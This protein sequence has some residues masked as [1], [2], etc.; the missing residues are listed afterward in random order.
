MYTIHHSPRPR[1]L[2]AALAVVVFA[3][4]CGD[5]APVAG[6]SHRE[7]ATRAAHAEQSVVPAVVAPSGD[8]G[9]AGVPLPFAG[10]INSAATVFRITQTGSGGSGGYEILNTGSGATALGAFTNGSGSAL[11]AVNGGAGRAGVVDITNANNATDALLART[12]G[13]GRAL[14]VDHIGPT[15]AIAVFQ[16]GSQNRIR[17]N[18]AGRGFFNGGTQVGGADLA[19]AFAVEGR[20]V[21]YEPGDVLV[22]SKRSDRRVVKSSGAYSPLVVGVYATKPGVLLTERGIDERMDDLVPMGVVGVIPTKVT[23]ENGTIRRGDLLV[24]ART[25]GHAMRGTDRTRML[26]ATIGKALQSFKGPG[27]GVI[28]V[29]VNVK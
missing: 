28:N 21:D 16:S 15:G 23:V 17:F 10:T 19:E 2:H 8:A 4:A 25:P 18:K 12:N 22:I 5:E 20:V 3:A 6:P 7:S 29:L 26:G 11:F 27:T 1:R 13:T 14:V 9:V 24:S